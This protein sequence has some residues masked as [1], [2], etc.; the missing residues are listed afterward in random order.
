MT[1]VIA[2]VCWSRAFRWRF[3]LRNCIFTTGR[4]H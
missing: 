4:I 1:G 2:D 3:S